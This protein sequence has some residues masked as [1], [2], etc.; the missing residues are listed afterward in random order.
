MRGG[1][2]EEH[3][4]GDRIGF[5][6]A[7]LHLWRVQPERRRLGFDHVA[8]DQPLEVGERAPLET[9]VRRADGRVLPH[10]EQSL[11]PIRP[12]IVPV[13]L[14][15][16]RHVEPVAEVRMIAADAR[17]PGEAELVLRRCPV[18]VPRLEQRDRVLVEVRPPASRRT[19][20]GEVSVERRIG[21]AERRHGEI[22]RQQIVERRDVGGALNRGV[23][24]ERQD[25]AARPS[26]VAEEQLQ[27]RCRADD[28]H[29]GRVL[30]EADGVA[31]GSRALG[32]RR[33]AERVGDPHE[34]IGR[35]AAHLFHHRR[36]VAREVAR[37]DLEHRARVLQRGI[38]FG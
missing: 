16:V 28:L 6:L 29:A 5:E 11:E 37:E 21:D 22:A 30:R 17:Q 15:T 38:S 13:G 3:L 25:A 32:A 8:H 23:A 18:A 14:M 27:D 9:R 2:E 10:D 19:M 35:H 1:G 20:R 24:A 12:S 33:A 34:R 31:D 4:G 26:D 36:R 7:A